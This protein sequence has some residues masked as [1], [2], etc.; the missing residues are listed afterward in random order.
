MKLER[1]GIRKPILVYSVRTYLRGD[2]INSLPTKL[3]DLKG[4]DSGCRLT[5]CQITSD[6]SGIGP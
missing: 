5:N 2:A 1:T 6:V 4:G 3:P